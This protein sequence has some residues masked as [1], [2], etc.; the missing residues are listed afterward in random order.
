MRV[1][2]DFSHGPSLLLCEIVGY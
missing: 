1:Y 2:I